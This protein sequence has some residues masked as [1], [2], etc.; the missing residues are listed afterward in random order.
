MVAVGLRHASREYGGLRCRFVGGVSGHRLNV[1]RLAGVTPHE[2]ET[3]QIRCGHKQT[4]ESAPP[5][6]LPSLSPGS[7]CG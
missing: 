6:L 1:N 4:Q 3:V 5:W 2:F 7:K